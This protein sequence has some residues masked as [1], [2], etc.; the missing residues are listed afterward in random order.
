MLMLGAKNGHIDVVNSSIRLGVELETKSKDGYTALSL[1]IVNNR[2][3]IVSLLVEKKANV[4]TVDCQRNSALHLAVSS[5]HEN[6]EIVQILLKA[7]VVT[8]VQNS[9]KET[10]L[11]AAKSSR[12]CRAILG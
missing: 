3:P 1:A 2:L 5:D 11:A 7:G 10:P 4:N 8:N 6:L 12:I 9:K